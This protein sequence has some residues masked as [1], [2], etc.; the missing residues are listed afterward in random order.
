M[1]NVFKVDELSKE[2]FDEVDFRF[3]KNNIP[4][5]LR[6][7]LV[8]IEHNKRKWKSLYM[9]VW[10]LPL[11][12][13]NPK[14]IDI[15][16]G[17][18]LILWGLPASKQRS[19]L[20]TPRELKSYLT[21]YDHDIHIGQV[22]KIFTLLE[23]YFISF[24]ELTE[25]SVSDKYSLLDTIKG[26]FHKKVNKGDFTRFYALKKYLK[27]NGFALTKDLLELELAKE[28]RNCFVHRRGLVNKRWLKVYKN[29]G[30]KDG[31]KIGDK[32]PTPFSDLE[33]LTDIMIRIVEKSLEHFKSSNP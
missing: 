27:D 28:T 4:E 7:L 29:T 26:I 6:S 17:D 1:N 11:Y 10:G 19:V 13:L 14:Y 16:Q 2:L 9:A 8:E 15:G 18:K 33:D 25:K 20:Y 12:H 32:V 31:Y 30:R 24:Y 3:N 23:N 5:E 21:D 22:I